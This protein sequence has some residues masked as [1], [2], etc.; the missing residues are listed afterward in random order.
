V[1]EMGDVRI[2]ID[3]DGIFSNRLPPV[4]HLGL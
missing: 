2:H 3:D 1:E 4:S